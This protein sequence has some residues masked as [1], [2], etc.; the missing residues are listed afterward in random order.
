M[1]ALDPS[2]PG[3]PLAGGGSGG[4]NVAEKLLGRLDADL[5]YTDIEDVINE[6]MHEYLD[7]LQT[8]IN[9]I[10]GG[11][12]TTFFNIKPPVEESSSQ[13]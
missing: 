2:A 5:E 1:S 3:L 10:D 9:Q 6:G 13:Q 7:R 11:I 4:G 12:G 8:R